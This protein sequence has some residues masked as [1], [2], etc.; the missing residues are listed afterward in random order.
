MTY[1]TLRLFIA[2]IILVSCRPSNKYEVIG[3]RENKPEFLATVYA[4]DTMWT[5]MEKFAKTFVA[6]KKDKKYKSYS[7][8]FYS[9]KET[10]LK[11]DAEGMPIVKSYEEAAH[12]Q[13]F[14]IATY[15][16]TSDDPTS[17]RFEHFNR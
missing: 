10:T 14:L 9:K 17:E 8:G 2:L 6:E 12:A 3:V 5:E 13:D 16:L 4:P 11:F 1:M 15:E 7:L